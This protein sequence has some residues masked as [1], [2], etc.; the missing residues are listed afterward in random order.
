[1]KKYLLLIFLITLGFTAYSQ[2]NEEEEIENEDIIDLDFDEE[3]LDDDFLELSA[4]FSF[5]LQPFIKISAG[6]ATPTYKGHTFENLDHFKAVL[7]FSKYDNEVVKDKDKNI[8]GT[9]REYSAYGLL[10]ESYD[11]NS[12][13]LTEKTTSPLTGFY[14]FGYSTSDGLGYILGENA[15]IILGQETSFGWQSMNY[16][17]EQMNA[18]EILLSG[19]SKESNLKRRYNDDVRFS[20]SFETFVKVRPFENL[21]VDF[22]YQRDLIFPRYMTWHAMASGITEGIVGQISNYFV[23]K[24]K[25]ASPYAAP[26]VNFV[27]QNTISY[28]F[29]ELRKENMNWPI[30]GEKPLI[31]NSMNFGINYHF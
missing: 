13:M 17:Y 27:L 29:T 24:V 18:A 25:K 3:E 9:L 31:I 19:E 5:K 1:M 6:I 20:Q 14:K 30:S 12:N 22:A 2:E 11:Y 21:S 10:I 23:K 28:V 4:G 15:D 7:G 8:K 16:N 26:V